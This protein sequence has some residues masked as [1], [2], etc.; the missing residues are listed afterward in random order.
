MPASATLIVSQQDP[1][2]YRTIAAALDAAQPGARIL[3]RPGQYDESLVID[4]PVALIGDGPR[5]KIILSSSAASCITMR[6]EQALVRGLTL[7]GGSMPQGQAFHAVDIPMGR[8]VLEDCDI[9]CESLACIAIHARQDK[10]IV[11]RCLIHHGKGGGIVVFGGADGLVEECKTFGNSHAGFAIAR[12]S[13]LTARRCQIYDDI[14]N[15]GNGSFEDCEIYSDVERALVAGRS[16]EIDVL[17]ARFDRK[18]SAALMGLLGVVTALAIS[19]CLAELAGWEPGFL[20]SLLVGLATGAMLAIGGLWYEMPALRLDSR[21]AA[22]AVIGG[23]GASFVGAEWIVG[24]ILGGMLIAA[25]MIGWELLFAPGSIIGIIAAIIGG[26][27][28]SGTMISSW[29]ALPFAPD[30]VRMMIG[31]GVGGAIIGVVVSYLEWDESIV[32]K[33]LRS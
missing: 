32:K 18:F 2:T 13:A 25:L 29:L 33:R 19:F 22:G 1:N 11:R 5:D 30:L 24:G 7:R 21:L 31:G 8:L 4:K 3:I 17:S 28:G 16:E 6:A 20:H 27:I 15:E 26:A 12:D 9:A 10:P 14:S 23:F